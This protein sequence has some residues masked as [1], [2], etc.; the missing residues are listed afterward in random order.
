M[1]TALRVIASGAALPITGS[2]WVQSP[3]AGPTLPAGAAG[4][5]P[6]RSAFQSWIIPSG[7]GVVHN[8]MPARDGGLLLTESGAGKVA[9][10][11]IE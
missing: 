11:T 5:S 8:M 4:T 1:S 9:L 10:V 7:G 6:R 3:A 2:A